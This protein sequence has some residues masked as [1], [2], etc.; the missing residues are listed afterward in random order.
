MHFLHPFFVWNFWDNK[1]PEAIASGFLAVLP[2]L[3]IESMP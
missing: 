3:D 1:K 2:D